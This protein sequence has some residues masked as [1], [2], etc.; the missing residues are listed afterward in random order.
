M[1]SVVAAPPA[2]SAVEGSMPPAG[3]A[4]AVIAVIG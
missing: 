3:F 1:I 2:P 4:F